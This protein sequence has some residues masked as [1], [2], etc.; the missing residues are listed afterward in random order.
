MRMMQMMQMQTRQMRD[1]KAI[2]RKLKSEG[3]SWD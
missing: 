3:W 2:S 1:F